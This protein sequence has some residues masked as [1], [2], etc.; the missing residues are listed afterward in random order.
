MVQ[1]H[2]GSHLMKIIKLFLI[3]T[4]ASLIP[5]QIVRLP[6]FSAPGAL[7]ISDIFAVSV[8]LIF[9]IF[10]LFVKKSLKLPPNTFFP[11]FLFMLSATASTILAVNVFKLAEIII[12]LLFLVRFIIYFFLSIII[13]NVVNKK[14]VDQWLKI[15]LSVGFLFIG[16][17]LF[18]FILFPDLSFLTVHGWD[19]HQQRIVS[20]LLDPNF[21]GF[22]FAAVFAISTSLYLYQQKELQ[23]ISFYPFLSAISF[24]ALILTFSRSSYLAFLTAIVTI[25]VLKSPKLF[26]AVLFLFAVAFS[27]IPQVKARIVGAFTLDET[28]KARIESWQKGLAIFKNNFLF[29]VGF[30][31]YRY[32]QVEYGFFSP[33]EPEGGHSGAGSD[34]S[35]ILVA[36]TTGI[37]GLFFYLFLLF[38]ILKIFMKR[39][40]KGYVHLASLSVFLALLVHSQFVNSL[41]FPQIMLLL[42]MILGLVQLY[43]T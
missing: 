8:D 7:T 24:I 1:I 38:R 4:L 39:A 10:A 9:L 35:I 17:G 32:A 28:S 14:D 21:S 22:V 5:G 29:G 36:A 31:T 18:Q 42:W 37:V 25:G 19:P 3:A 27:Q 43:D 11:A 13:Y 2:L 16:L 30:N 23:I 41:F 12:S 33:D 34:S 20:T 26:F 40:T 6:F 15:I